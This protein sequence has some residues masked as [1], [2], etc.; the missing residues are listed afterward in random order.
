ML[1][2]PDSRSLFTVVVS[3]AGGSVTSATATVT[4]NSPAPTATNLA[5]SKSATSSGDESQNLAP[6]NAIDGNL[7]TRWSSAFVDS[8]WLQ[9][10]LGAATALNKVVM[11]WEAAYGKAYKIQVSNDSVTWS[12]VYTQTAGQGGVETV[13]FPTVTGRFIRM[14][15]VTRALPYGYSL[16]EFQ[17]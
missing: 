16:F 15:G 11:Y 12:T 3:N 1:S 6:I 17:V 8:A 9:V 5:L 13:T 10:D 2:L 14:Q 4:V 7:A